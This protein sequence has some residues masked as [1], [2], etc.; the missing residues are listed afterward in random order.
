M[1]RKIIQD[2]FECEYCQK[3]G[4]KKDILKHERVCSS[5]NKDDLKRRQER[6]RIYQAETLDEAE[7][8]LNIYLLKYY[9]SYYTNA[10]GSKVK[11]RLNT[12]RV[13]APFI[14]A[15]INN[16]SNI[17]YTHPYSTHFIYSLDRFVNIVNKLESMKVLEKELSKVKLEY[18]KE[19]EKIYEKMINCSE[20]YSV[21]IRVRDK[22]YAEYTSADFKLKELS[23][24]IHEKA[25]SEA[26][27][28]FDFKNT[29]DN[30]NQIKKDLRV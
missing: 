14:Q 8:L 30:Y 25:K 28:K 1:K 12:I 11:L 7:E 15:F 20:D 29:E 6:D 19:K 2:I 16:N 18:I 13:N 23:K 27:D 9:S 17:A 10:M 5:N 24:L 22:A 26:L 21:H 4:T 3:Q